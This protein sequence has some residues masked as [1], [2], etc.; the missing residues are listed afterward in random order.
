[1]QVCLTCFSLFL[2]CASLILCHSL[3]RKFHELNQAYELLLD[4]LRRLAL[5][6]KLRLKLARA[7]R[8]KAYDNKRKTML[9][10]LEAAEQA[11]KKARVEKQKEEAARWQ[12]T[13]QI[14]EEGRK[15]REAKEREIRQM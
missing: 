15:M 10:E 2:D 7:E 1:M 4:P 12:Q 11:N 13:E 8:Y 9:D 6:A 5:D 14:K 3:A